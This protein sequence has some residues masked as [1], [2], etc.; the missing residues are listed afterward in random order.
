MPDFLY[1]FLT[2]LSV[3]LAQLLINILFLVMSNLIQ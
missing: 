2:Y 1:I 3:S